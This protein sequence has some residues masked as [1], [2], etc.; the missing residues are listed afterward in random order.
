MWSAYLTLQPLDHRD[1]K[2]ICLLLAALTVSCLAQVGDIAAIL[3]LQAAGTTTE[4]VST[5]S[6]KSSS[7][8]GAVAE[9]TEVAPGGSNDAKKAPSLLP[10]ITLSLG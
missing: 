1:I 8:G 10:P 2:M 4:D 7:E 6:V 3:G 5:S 9:S